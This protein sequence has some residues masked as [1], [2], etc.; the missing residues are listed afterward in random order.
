M[1]SRQTFKHFI[2]ILLIVTLPACASIGKKWREFLS[3]EKKKPQT[4]VVSEGPNFNDNKNMPPSAKRQYRR[5]T[6]QSLQEEAHLDDR[7][8]S[9]WVMEGQGAYLFAQNTIRLIGDPVPISIDGDPKEQL[10]T[11]VAVIK[12]LMD[13]IEARQREQIERNL[14]EENGGA[15]PPAAPA[16]PEA[17][18]AKPKPEPNK[19]AKEDKTDFKVA[20]VPARIV[21]RTV[22]GNYRVKGSQPFNIGTRDY[23][24]IVTGIVRAE[25][26]SEDG[27]SATKLLDPKFD[28]VSARQAEGESI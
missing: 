20:T 4:E 8:G 3:G 1:K 18:A 23:K 5:T 11:K 26:F 17:A 25:D 2:A 28:V 19:D 15:A 22:D 24:V 21:E 27:V 14:A 6:R 16:A 12:K 10:Q 7:S 13:R 9:L